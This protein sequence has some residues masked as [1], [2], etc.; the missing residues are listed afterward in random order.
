MS[1]FGSIIHDSRT[2]KNLTLAELASQTGYSSQ[3]L[4]DIEKGY[5]EPSS[6]ILIE[7]LS[8]KLDINSD[9]LYFYAGKIPRDIKNIE[10]SDEQILEAF[11]VLRKALK[12]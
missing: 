9:I 2:K 7:K 10:A 5:R 3:Y 6:G 11:K 12:A 1:T 4:C 8:S